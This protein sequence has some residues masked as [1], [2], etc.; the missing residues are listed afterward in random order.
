MKRWICVAVLA[1]IASRRFGLRR[2]GRRK[3]PL[4]AGGDEYPASRPRRPTH[5]QNRR[6]PAL[7]RRRGA[8]QEIDCRAD[9]CKFD[10]YYFFGK[11]FNLARPER[12]NILFIAGGPGALVDNV[13]QTGR[14]LGYLEA[15]HN[16]VYFDLRGGGRSVIP[17][18]NKFDRFLRGQ[19]VA[20]DIEKIRKAVLD[21]KPWDAIYSHSWGACRRN[22]TRLNSARKK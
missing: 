13:N 11:G 21:R 5:A 1:I 22:C 4:E 2:R 8:A 15:H 3:L 12:K 10:L 20:D 17:A 9:A 16:V 19:Y 14:M 7:A 18:S 6:C